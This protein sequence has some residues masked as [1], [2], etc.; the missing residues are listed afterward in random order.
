MSE[1]DAVS[2]S[3]VA[4]APRLLHSVD[5]GIRNLAR[6]VVDL[7]TGKLVDWQLLDCSRG[8][9]GNLNQTRI[10]DIVR[11]CGIA[12]TELADRLTTLPAETVLIELQPRFNQKMM[13]LQYCFFNFLA[14]AFSR[15]GQYPKFHFVT[16]SLKLRPELLGIEDEPENRGTELA[17]QYRA[18][19]RYT[20][21]HCGEVLRRRG[22]DLRALWFE[23]QGGKRDDLADC[24]L[25]AVAW[26]ANQSLAGRPRARARTHAKRPRESKTVRAKKLY[27]RAVASDAHLMS[28]SSSAA[29]SAAAAA[30]PPKPKPKPVRDAS[31]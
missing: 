20:K 14:G 3:A 16:P 5:V 11:M 8:F 22:D 4:A 9:E 19:K 25:Q 23:S 18:N 21:D 26:L 28:S 1:S 24:Y 31:E 29:A 7:D 27:A 6:A 30:A 2:L 10:E 12:W 13:I 15:A 17:S